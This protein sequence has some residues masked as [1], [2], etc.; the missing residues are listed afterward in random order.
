[1]PTGTRSSPTTS[2]TAS[3]ASSRADPSNAAS[4]R[5]PISRPRSTRSWRWRGRV[6]WLLARLGLQMCGD[7]WLYWHIRGKNLTAREYATSFLGADTGGSPTV[8]RAGA[9]MTAGLASDML[10]QFDRANDEWAEAYRIAEGLRTPIASSASEPS[11]G[12][13]ACSGSTYRSRAPADEGKHRAEPRPRLHLGR[14]LRVEF[15]WHPP[16]LCRRSRHRA[17][18]VFPGAPDP[19]GHWRPGRR[20][21]VARRPR[22]AGDRSR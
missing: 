5:R 16:D 4:P 19:A 17:D 20:R 22:R 12:V 2:A 21:P 15:R 8:G 11:S 13:W 9:L 14:G 10:G 18:E 7:L 6:T 1:M 3:R